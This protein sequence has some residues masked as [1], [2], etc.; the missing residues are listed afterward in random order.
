MSESIIQ[1]VIDQ[2]ILKT[3]EHSAGNTL[4]ELL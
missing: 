3:K 4:V 2:G 1:N